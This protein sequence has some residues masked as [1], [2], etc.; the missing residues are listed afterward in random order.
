MEVEEVQAA[1]VLV[2]GVVIVVAPEEVVSHLVPLMEAGGA[3][4]AHPDLVTSAPG[5]PHPGV[6][7]RVGV[8]HEARL[9]R[10]LRLRALLDAL[11]PEAALEDAARAVW[12]GEAEGRIVHPASDLAIPVLPHSA[13]Q[14]RTGGGILRTFHYSKYL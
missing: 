2:H 10:A 1:V 9:T 6:T 8:A 14:I 4:R 13:Q 7:P 11:R 5:L 3:A 12:A